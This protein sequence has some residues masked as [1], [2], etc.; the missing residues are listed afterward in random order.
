MCDLCMHLCIQEV[1]WIWI[2]YRIVYYTSHPQV[3][4]FPLIFLNST[5]NSNLYCYANRFRQDGKI[6]VILKYV[7]DSVSQELWVFTSVAGTMITT[8][9]ISFCI[10]NWFIMTI[11]VNV[12]AWRAFII[13]VVN[14]QQVVN[15]SQFSIFNYSLGVVIYWC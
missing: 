8:T 4:R 1:A 13:L 2:K 5:N 15:L 14:L 3:Y 6:C 10:G 11:S 12:T 9:I 7:K